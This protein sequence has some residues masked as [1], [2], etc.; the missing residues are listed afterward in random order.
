[1]TWNEFQ[2]ANKGKDS[3]SDMSEAWSKYKQENCPNGGEHYLHRP[4]IRK[5]ILDEIN[6]NTRRNSKGQIWDPISKK[7]ADPNNVE[8][9]HV[10]GHEF[11]YERDR[12]ESKGW[13]QSQFN[14]YMN[15]SSF[16]VW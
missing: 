6:A 16:Y 15:D 12:A 3:E 1:M 5:K 4:Y 11:W 2:K 13:T 10:K 7:W 9:G 14:E 8:L